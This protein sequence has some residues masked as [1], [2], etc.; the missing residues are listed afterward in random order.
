MQDYL[1]RTQKRLEPPEGDFASYIKK[2][3]SD[4]L[5][6][7][8]PAIFADELPS[9]ALLTAPD[10]RQKLFKPQ[11]IKRFEDSPVPAAPAAT[12]GT[13]KK[14]DS[15]N[16]GQ[17]SPTEKKDRPRPSILVKSRTAGDLQQNSKVPKPPAVR[18][19]FFGL[20]LFTVL[21]L[22]IIQMFVVKLPA[23]IVFAS[24]TFIIL[25]LLIFKR[26]IDKK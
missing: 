12:T 7:L 25:S 1:K 26:L 8:D 16:R 23:W 9:P 10:T 20:L 22:G 19:S 14:N 17:D 13:I 4:T 24:C 5:L 3:Q 21:L 18:G 2:L 15:F 6:P 11:K